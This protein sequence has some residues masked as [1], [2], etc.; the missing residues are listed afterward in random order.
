MLA[1]G[2]AGAPVGARSP[3]AAGRACSELAAQTDDAVAARRAA[4]DTQQGAWKAVI[5]VGVAA[6]YAG[7]TAALAQAEQRLAALRSE[8]SRLHCAHTSSES[9]VIR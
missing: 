6:R 9:T 4:L 7:G 1:A 3:E 5:P 2:C 8:A